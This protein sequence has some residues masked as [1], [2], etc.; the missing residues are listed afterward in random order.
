MFNN[1]DQRRR[2]LQEI[3]QKFR[4][5][6]ATAPEKA[7]TIQ[8]LGLPPRFEQAMQR[9]LGQSGIIV[10]VNGKYYLN[11]ERLKQIQEQRANMAG[12]SG[13][14]GRQGG[15]PGWMRYGGIL[16]MLPI[17]IIVIG[18]LLFYLYVYHGAGYFPGEIL[19]ILL[20]VLI[21][22]FVARMLFWRARRKYR[23]DR[24]TQNT[25]PYQQ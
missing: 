24:W 22:M 10:E 19:L 11:E 23:R 9:R 12:G 20:V 8:E 6:G 13:G 25:A 21:V 1:Q 17:G 3:I 2:R 7:M 18:L 16:L 14:Y 15:A 5:K 4:E